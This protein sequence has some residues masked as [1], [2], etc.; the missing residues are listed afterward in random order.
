MFSAR[1]SDGRL[2]AKHDYFAFEVA[3]ELADVRVVSV[4]YGGAAVRQGLDQ[5]VFGA[6]DACERVEKFQVYRTD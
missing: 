1:T 3:A 4:K 2:Q 5:F 6:G